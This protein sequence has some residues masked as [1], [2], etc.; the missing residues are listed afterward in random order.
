MEFRIADTFTDSLAKLTGEEQ[1]AVKNC[2]LTIP[3]MLSRSGGNTGCR[4]LV[5]ALPARLGCSGDLR[6]GAG[7]RQGITPWQST[8]R[9]C[10]V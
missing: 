2:S 6:P 10:F 8:A 7:Q 3:T 5:E 1:K 9:S 4:H